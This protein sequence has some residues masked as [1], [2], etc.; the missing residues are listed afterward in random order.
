MQRSCNFL[1]GNYYHVYNRGVEKRL[2][3]KQESDWK[4]FQALLY[5]CNGQKPLV[6]RYIFGDPLEYERGTALVSIVAY[7]LMPNHFHLLVREDIAGGLSKFMAR[8]LT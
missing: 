7:S 2:I 6:Y 8:L 4:H 1:P 3:F 5:L